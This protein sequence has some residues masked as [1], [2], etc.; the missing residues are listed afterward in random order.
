MSD[1][2]S[3]DLPLISIAL[4]TYDGKAYLREQ[5]ESL[6]AQTYKHFEIVAVDD[7]STDETMSILHEFQ[8]RDSRIKVFR[9]S[10]NLGFRKNFERAMSLC[11]APL[12]APCDQDDIWLP[13]KLAML[14]DAIGNHDLAYCDSE[15]VNESGESLGL[16][17]SD[18]TTMMSTSDPAVFAASNCVSGHSM[19]FRRKLLTHAF[20]VPECFYYDW[21]IAAIAASSNGVAHVHRKLVKYRLH[22]SNVTNVLRFRPVERAPGHRWM[23]LKDFGMRL[24]LLA[25]LASPSRSFIVRFRDL[26]LKRECQW[27][28]PALAWFIFRHAPRIFALR[29]Q[30]RTRLHYAVK[31]LVGLRLKRLTNPLAYAPVREEQLDERSR[32]AFFP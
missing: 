13:E 25:E 11:S 12:I 3:K 6:F 23:L 5:L 24:Q 31:H 10:T 15:L 20:P 27:F 21:W 2:S 32:T 19:M 28:S 14:F 8:S 29:K 1:F 7:C 17:M 18:T 22:G 4:C 16:A 30:S 9:N 26:W